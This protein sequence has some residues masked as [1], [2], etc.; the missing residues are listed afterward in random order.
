MSRH[1]PCCSTGSHLHVDEPVWEPLLEAVG[2]RLAGPFMWMY[3][4]QLADGTVVHAYKHSYTRRYLFLDEELQA[5][6][7]TACG[8][9]SPTPLD[10]AIQETLCPWFL[11]SGMENEDRQALEEAIRR[12]SDLAS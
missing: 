11:S 12:T 1:L 3:A 7:Y 6:T 4:S 8:A 10:W 5:F 2:D 9:Y